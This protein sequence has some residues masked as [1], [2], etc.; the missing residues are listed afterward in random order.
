MSISSSFDR[1]NVSLPSCL[2]M[3][4]TANSVADYFEFVSW[5]RIALKRGLCGVEDEI[6]CVG[7]GVAH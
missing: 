1:N 6:A 7:V 4:S 3:S 2:M 5:T